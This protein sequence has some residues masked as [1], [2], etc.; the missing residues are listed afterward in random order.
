MPNKTP[1]PSVKKRLFNEIHQECINKSDDRG[2][3]NPELLLR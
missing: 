3:L 2:Q 1:K